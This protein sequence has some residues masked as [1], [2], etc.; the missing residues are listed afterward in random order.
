MTKRVKMIILR[1]GDP[2][3]KVNNLEEMKKLILFVS[4]KAKE[5]KVDR[6]EI[7]GDLF[8][9]HAVLRLEVINFWTWALDFL[10]KDFETVILEGNHD[11]SGNYADDFSALS[12]FALMN[13]PNL[14]IINKPTLLGV[15]A[16]VPYTHDNATFISSAGHLSESGG[17]V[18]VCH[19]TIAGS[20]YESGVY[21]PDGIP[22]GEWSKR[23]THIISGHIHSE[24]SFGNVIYPGTARWDTVADANRRKGIWIFRHADNGTIESALCISTEEVCSPIR[25][26]EWREGEHKDIDGEHG[27]TLNS[28]VTVELIGSSAWVAAQKKKL[29][30]KCSVKAKITDR[31]TSQN[32]QSGNSLEHFLNNLFVTNM[33]KS[34]LL[35]YAK[36]IGIV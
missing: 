32:R 1:V 21:A 25:C 22:T 5:F 7:L 26:I 24:Q 18:L 14:I 4:S 15:F 2:H 27:W 13:K 17:K 29:Q 10:S 3:A 28:R 16:Y 23:F 9:T 11:Q 33:D 35:K 36:E 19:Q 31:K 6:I 8:H 34:S 12:I 20:K 30:G